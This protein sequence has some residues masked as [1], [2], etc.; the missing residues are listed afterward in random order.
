M[1]YLISPMRMFVDEVK[2]IQSFCKWQG[3]NINFLG[4]STPLFTQYFKGNNPVILIFGELDKEPTIIYGFLNF[5]RYMDKCG[6][7]RI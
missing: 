6:M 1:I 4:S 3:I 2:L 7:Y 5:V